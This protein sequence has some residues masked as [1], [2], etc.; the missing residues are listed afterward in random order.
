MSLDAYCELERIFETYTLLKRNLSILNWD[1]AVM[2]PKGA[3]VIRGKQTSAQCAVMHSTLTAPNVASLLG[4]AEKKQEVLNEWQ[5]ANLREMQRIYRLCVA[6]PEDVQTRFTEQT[7]I[8]ELVWREAKKKDSF[9][10]FQESFAPLLDLIKQRAEYLAEAFEVTPYEGLMQE[11]DPGS[12]QA[13]LDSMFMALSEQLPLL[14]KQLTEAQNTASHTSTTLPPIPKVTQQKLCRAV[15]TDLG[16]DF[17][18]G[19][20]DESAHPFTEGSTEDIRITTHY[21]KQNPLKGLLAAMHECGHSLY[22]L[23]LPKKWALQPVGYDRSMVVHEGIALFYE[24][25]L[26]RTRPFTEYLSKQMATLNI[27]CDAKTL[28]HEL[29]RIR[30]GTIRIEADG[31]TYVP[32]IILRY[33]IETRVLNGT[34]AISEIPEYWNARMQELLGF[35]VTSTSYNEGC[36]QDI[37]WSLGLFGYFPSYAKGL[38]LAFNL[39]DK[40]Q[41]HISLMDFGALLSALI[42][43]IFSQ[44]SLHCA[45]PESLMRFSPDVL[46]SYF[47]NRL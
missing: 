17:N 16:F 24:M 21:S 9:A 22:E 32:H 27:A 25:V 40:Y 13:E 43:D 33:D 35:G 46:V 26:A 44:G 15:L 36:L 7:V 12:K 19:R 39:H 30:P 18:H 5:Q 38:L 31:L 14:V 2:M 10:L 23:H 28:H 47:K 6:V 3:S 8:T 41:S 42:H 20:L 29:T 34:L 45:L 11:Y 37:H 1:S 4:K